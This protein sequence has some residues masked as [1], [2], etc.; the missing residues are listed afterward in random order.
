MSSVLT[1][2]QFAIGCGSLLA[3]VFLILLALPQSRLRVFL[4]PIVGWSLAIF[5]AFYCISPVD[6]VPEAFLGPFGLIDDVV[7]LSG[8]IAAAMA[9]RE[10]GREQ[11]QES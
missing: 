6:L 7:A 2:V 9:A 5:C 3:V 11:S 1:L 10:A 4:M 8:G